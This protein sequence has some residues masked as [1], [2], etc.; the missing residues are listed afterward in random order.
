MLSQVIVILFGT[1]G[2]PRLFAPP[3]LVALFPALAAGQRLALSSKR[4]G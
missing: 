1:S 3:C 2:P 4:V